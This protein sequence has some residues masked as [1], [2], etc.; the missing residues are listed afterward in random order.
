MATYTVKDPTSGKTVTLQGDS[1]P[2]EQELEDIFSK[3]N[4]AQPQS[5]FAEDV[6][7]N[8]KREVVGI[9]KSIPK[10][11]QQGLDIGSLPSD[12]LKYPLQ[13][14]M[15]KPSA[16][17]PLAEDL[18]T[19]GAIPGGTIQMLSDLGRSVTSPVKSFRK[20]PISTAMNIASL[21][22]PAGKLLSGL[23][24]GAMAGEAGMAAEAASATPSVGTRVLA[25]GLRVGVGIP[26][27]ATISRMKNPAA[28]KSAFSHAEVADQVV[29]SV[30]NFDGKISALAEDAA[31][32]LRSSPYIEEG[33][34][35]KTDVLKV[36]KNARAEIGGAYTPEK[37][38]AIKVIKSI[39]TD[40]AKK[41]K[42]AVSEAQIKE[43]IK[44]LDSNINWADPTASTRNRAL[45]GI[46]VRLDKILKGQ[47][48]AYK[49][50][51]VPVDEAVRVQ[52]KMQST[53]GIGKETARGFH[54]TD[55]TVS[56]VKRALT[57]DKLQTQ[58]VISRFE[59]ISGEDLTSRIKNANAKALFEGADITPG[60]Y[61]RGVVGAAGG[62]MIGH[63]AGLP[64]AMGAA[65]GGIAGAF[66]DIY[67]RAGAAKIIDALASPA[68][69]RYI[70]ILEKA[71]AQGAKNLAA[72]HQL[73]M[74]TDS[75]YASG[76]GGKS[77]AIKN[78][79][80][81]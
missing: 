15:G 24:T 38:S 81:P 46:R 8:A 5:S 31:K 3:I 22:I 12:A 55:Q 13:R 14:L 28:V 52:D 67:G 35:P 1:P 37:S 21:L 16:E 78:A 26:E 4:T 32:T 76:V 9:A 57:E 47:N 41:L 70:P 62:E 75:K 36:F 20:A 34:V 59:K 27:E 33:A 48:P 69:N 7:K 50:A 71:A 68:L 43:R 80:K 17:T 29:E 54:V 42:S 66:V 25:K 79:R 77:T 30:K 11:I 58:D 72:T 65:L 63:L 44:E 73:L 49:E 19:L 56:K 23:K 64:P 2:S 39:E 45:I 6:V 60:R 10:T 61:S 18:G 51:M 40:F 53:F 74:E